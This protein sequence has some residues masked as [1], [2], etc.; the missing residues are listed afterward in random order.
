MEA[1]PLRNTA[2]HP[3][4]QQEV[5]G[6]QILLDEMHRRQHIPSDLG[7]GN[8]INAVGA[9]MGPR[10]GSISSTTAEIEE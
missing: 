5:P 4:K 8:M 2:T 1:G 7:D 3:D 6:S 10:L 9:G